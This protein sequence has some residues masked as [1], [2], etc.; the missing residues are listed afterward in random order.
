MF[1]AQCSHQTWPSPAGK[2]GRYFPLCGKLGD[3]E[4]DLWA[5]R[6]HR[7]W[8]IKAQN[9]QIKT[10][11]VCLNRRP[12]RRRPLGSDSSSVFCSASFAKST[13]PAG[14]GYF[15]AQ[16][17]FCLNREKILLPLRGD[18]IFSHFVSTIS[19]RDRRPRRSFIN[20]M[21]IT[22]FIVVIFISFTEILFSQIFWF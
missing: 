11:V 20:L 8:R 10:S 13:F 3:E 19:C 15:F 9:K 16:I 1:G 22:N 2:W 17:L 21:I 12:W 4:S 5:N 14:E 6:R 18:F 7:R